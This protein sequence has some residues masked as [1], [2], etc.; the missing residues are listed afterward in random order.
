[1]EFHKQ[2]GQYLKDAVYAAN[3]GIV[4]TFAVVAGVVGASFD[5]VIILILGVANLLADGFSMASGNYLGSRSETDLYHQ[6]RRR[7]EREMDEMR[8]EERKEIEEILKK[9]GY[10]GEDLEKMLAL[11][12]GNKKFAVDLMMSEEIGMLRPKEGQEMRGA[13]V[14]F[15]SFLI[16]GAVPLI[17]Y[18]FFAASPNAFLFAIVFTSLALFAVGALRV[19]FIGKGWLISGLEMFFVG[20]IAAAIAYGVGFVLRQFINIL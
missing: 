2:G 14:T 18:L 11:I 10:Q 13:I 16:A 19:I 8:N 4:T 3:D 12:M 17:P 7:E 9:G 20:G 6:E 5:P 15:F 1:M